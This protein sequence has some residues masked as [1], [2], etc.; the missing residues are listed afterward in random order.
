MCA[1]TMY[2]CI[3]FV[4]Q[5]EWCLITCTQQTLVVRTHVACACMRTM[6]VYTSEYDHDSVCMSHVHEREWITTL[7]V[8]HFIPTTLPVTL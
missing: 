5:R 6:F 2:I 3:S 7:A 4:L 8:S 1:Y